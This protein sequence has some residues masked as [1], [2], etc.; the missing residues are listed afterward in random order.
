[1][2][3]FFAILAMAALVIAFA[4]VA[5]AQT[6]APT[7]TV[8]A[9]S[10]VPVSITSTPVVN[11]SA[12]PEPTLAIATPANTPLPATSTPALPEEG[13]PPGAVLGGHLYIDQDGSRSLTAGDTAAPATVYI[14]LLDDTGTRLL[15]EAV[16]SDISGRWEIRAILPGT[17]RISWV[18][19]LTDP[20]PADLARTIP[21]AA[22]IILSPLTT[23]TRPSRIVQVKDSERI[24]NIDFGM[25]PQS[26]AI[27]SAKPQLPRTGAGGGRGVT[28]NEIIL[29]VGL[30]V[31]TA[32][33]LGLVVRRRRGA[34]G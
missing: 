30:A 3:R 9:A 17:Y 25:P 8:A 34:H 20:K 2:H 31:S 5:N 12:T 22:P 4:P 29:F 19:P 6:P 32:L 10:T 14:D 11:N 16:Q 7:S 23:V 13:G 33:G 28:A 15:N 1:M 18:P 24:L 21:P 26:Q 27:G